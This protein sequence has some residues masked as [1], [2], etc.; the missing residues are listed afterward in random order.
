MIVDEII[1][2]YLK[3]NG[4]DGLCNPDMECGCKLE[5]FRPCGEDFGECEPAYDCGPCAHC[6]EDYDIFMST[7]KPKGNGNDE[8]H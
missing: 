5:D 2:K 6:G 1:K 3:D 7:E 8:P 4:F